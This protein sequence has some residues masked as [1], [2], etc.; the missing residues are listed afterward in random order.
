MFYQFLITNYFPIISGLPGNP[1]VQGL[2][3]PEGPQ[4]ELGIKVE[5]I[6]CLEYVKITLRT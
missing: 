6:N 1:G 4:G 3:G 5:L 2:A